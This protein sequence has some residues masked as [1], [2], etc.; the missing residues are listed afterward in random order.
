MVKRTVFGLL[1]MAGIMFV[2][3]AFYR[4]SSSSEA[5][6][7][8]DLTK[9]VK[10]STQETLDVSDGE[11]RKIPEEKLA[12]LKLDIDNRVKRNRGVGHIDVYNTL[13]WNN[14]V[15]SDS[16]L[17]EI[18]SVVAQLYQNKLNDKNESAQYVVEFAEFRE[19][20]LEQF[21]QQVFYYITELGLLTVQLR[22]SIYDINAGTEESKLVALTLR[23]DEEGK[24]VLVE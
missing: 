20:D 24:I 5:I 22:L 12:E 18:R 3:F 7:Q 8:D 16:E 11:I 2:I 17:N 14:K 9:D 10:L 13:D 6:E 1:I 15:I 21:S 23:C 4:Y 19:G